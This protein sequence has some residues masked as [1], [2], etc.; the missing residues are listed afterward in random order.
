MM[1]DRLKTS[2]VGATELDT[3]VANM[4]NLTVSTPQDEVMTLVDA[5]AGLT[6]VGTKELQGEEDI[7]R[8]LLS[9]QE[10]AMTLLSYAFDGMHINLNVETDE[11][12]NEIQVRLEPGENWHAG[13]S[14]IAS[15]WLAQ[16][17]P[18]K[19]RVRHGGSLYDQ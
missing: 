17:W 15:G 2:V 16:E 18:N 14:R 4:A 19:A 5:M 8:S 7:Q 9:K 13:V 11:E 6:V 3:V 10:T 12:A 1:L